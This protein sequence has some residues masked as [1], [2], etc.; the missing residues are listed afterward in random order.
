MV[1]S[2]Y[3]YPYP[4]RDLCLYL[5]LFRVHAR[6]LDRHWSWGAAVAVTVDVQQSQVQYSV[7]SWRKVECDSA[8]ACGSSA[9]E[10]PAPVPFRAVHAPSP[11]LVG[12]DQR[13]GQARR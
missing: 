13:K 10:Y 8:E 6:G 11:S 2:S 1:S 5:C 7:H 3:P 9:H 4:S 12:H